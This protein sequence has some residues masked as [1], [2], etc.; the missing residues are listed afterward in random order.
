MEIGKEFKSINSYNNEMG[1]V[2][3]D[4]LFF[5]NEI[6]DM[7]DITA[8]VDFGCADGRMTAE[9]LKHTSE[10]CL[11]IGYDIS[12]TM[13][14]F[15]RSNFPYQTN[16]VVFT[17]KWQKVENFI[18]TMDGEGKTMLVL[19]SVIHEVYSYQNPDNPDTNIDEFWRR[20][21]GTN[22][23]YIVIRDMM[24]SED[25]KRPTDIYD[26]HHVL[27]DFALSGY[28][29]SFQ[30][31]WGDMQKNLNFVHFLLKHKWTINWER[32]VNENY[33]PLFIENLILLI[34]RNAKYNIT[35]LKRF[36]PL[37][38]VVKERFNF[39]MV[40]DTHVKIIL[41]RRMS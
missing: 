38:D 16:R 18:N 10:E 7:D 41:K 1:K 20:V 3:N 15:A 25:I 40:D 24:P 36:C 5:L 26:L 6:E 23:D 8:I 14:Q 4:K 17:N 33:F 2:M 32:E 21:F 39:T 34:Q 13:I 27:N 37:R 31:R 19:S 28:V 35:Y 30:E 29:K 9:L 22:F 11:L 12:E